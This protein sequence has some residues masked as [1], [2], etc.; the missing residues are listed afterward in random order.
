[1][2]GVRHAVEAIWWRP[3]PPPWPLR[4]LEPLYA[5]V[6]D[7]RAARLKARATRLPVPVVMV[8]NIAV[9]GT[10]KTPVTLAVIE[11]LQALGARPGVL[12]RGYGGTGPFPR[13]LGAQ[14]TAAEV[15]D[16]PV[17][18]ARRSGVPVCVAPSRIAAGTA[19][20]A[21]HPEVDVLVCDDGLQHYALARDI[22]LCVV[23][24]AR[25]HGNGHRLPAG[26]LREPPARMA[27]CDLVL[28][29]GGDAAAHG[30]KALRFD[31]VSDEAIGLHGGVRR[32][33]A[34][35]AGQ[36]VDALAGIGHPQRFFDQLAAQGMAVRGHAFADHHA[37]TAADLAF[38]G[39]A[40]LLMTE[41]D[42]VKCRALALPPGLEAWVVPVRAVFAGDGAARVQECLRAALAPT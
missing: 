28:V 32:P 36:T 41:K 8:G 2:S 22:E 42:A 37:Y 11:A 20:L 18:I 3:E 38:A 31:L 26:P 19:L 10:G 17:L 33:L 14:S 23:D 9:G 24:G 30:A 6:A 5:A 12:S 21:A 29:N 27:A 15:G 40:P 13:L 7:R 4:L 39:A 16:E 35:F 1:M 25:G 34:S